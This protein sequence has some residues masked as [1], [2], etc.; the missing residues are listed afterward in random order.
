MYSTRNEGK[1]INNI[2]DTEGYIF[3]DIYMYKRNY[4]AMGIRKG[5]RK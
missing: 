5:T 1:I 3:T 2:I 4:M